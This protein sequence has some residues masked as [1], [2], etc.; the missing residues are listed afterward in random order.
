MESLRGKPANTPAST[1]CKHA[2]ACRLSHGATFPHLVGQEDPP[3]ACAWPIWVRWQAPAVQSALNIWV[4][5]PQSTP[6]KEA[7]RPPKSWANPMA[8]REPGDESLCPALQ[9][10]PWC[11]LPHRE[12]WAPLYP[13][14]TGA[15]AAGVEKWSGL[16]T[17]LLEQGG[18]HLPFVPARQAGTRGD[19]LGQSAHRAVVPRSGA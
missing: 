10:C 1:G 9:S 5:C 12:S 2:P 7:N 16:P 14:P 8:S 3:P 13:T 18:R 6:T 19:G 11:L 4:S 17:P 15:A